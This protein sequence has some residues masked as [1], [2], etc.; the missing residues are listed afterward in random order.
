M[1]LSMRVHVPLP[2][3]NA[4]YDP[5]GAGLPLATLAQWTPEPN[6]P[7]DRS[8]FSVAVGHKLKTMPG[9]EH[10]IVS[11]KQSYYEFGHAIG[12]Y[13]SQYDGFRYEEGGVVY[14]DNKPLFPIKPVAGVKAG[15][16]N[17]GDTGRSFAGFLW[18]EKP[19]SIAG[20]SYVGQAKMARNYFAQTHEYAQAD[21][22]LAAY[23]ID[24]SQDPSFISTMNSTGTPA[25]W[26]GWG[27]YVLPSYAALGIKLIIKMPKLTTITPSVHAF[28]AKVKQF[29]GANVAFAMNLNPGDP[30][31]DQF[32]AALGGSEYIDWFNVTTIGTLVHADGSGVEPALPVET[33]KTQVWN[34]PA[35]ASRHVCIESGGDSL[36]V[37]NQL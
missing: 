5:S 19:A 25:Q 4:D 34:N 29:L 8:A 1:K 36:L 37:L 17:M 30:L 21:A 32:V 27:N 23:F 15:P 31:R 16:S 33:F 20:N 11:T 35:Y 6:M 26:I 2:R 24:F 10:L 28:I 12:Y 13:S 18:L 3:F 14:A 9:V 22:P 7:R